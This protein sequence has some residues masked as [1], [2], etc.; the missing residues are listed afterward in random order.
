MLHV[1]HDSKIH[2]HAHSEHTLNY[3]TK[4]FVTVNVRIS[5]INYGLEFVDKNSDLQTY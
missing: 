1:W 2:L 4:T 5:Y 3:I